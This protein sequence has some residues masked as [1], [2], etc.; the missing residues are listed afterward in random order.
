M[1]D[2]RWVPFIVQRSPGPNRPH[3]MTRSS[4]RPREG[5]GLWVG[6]VPCSGLGLAAVKCE[7]VRVITALRKAGVAVSETACGFWGK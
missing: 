4:A 7:C 6:G 3:Y 2:E 5:L 1:N